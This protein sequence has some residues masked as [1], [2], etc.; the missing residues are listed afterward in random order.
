[1]LC[2]VTLISLQNILATRKHFVDVSIS[3]R[4]RLR[5]VAYGDTVDDV[6]NCLFQAA[7]KDR[8]IELT[9]GLLS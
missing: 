4:K 9:T 3:N 6:K 7:D 8:R 2:E 5:L 1:M